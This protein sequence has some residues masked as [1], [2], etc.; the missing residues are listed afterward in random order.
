MKH[1]SGKLRDF[2][3]K[4]SLEK[5]KRKY[6]KPNTIKKYTKYFIIDSFLIL[7]GVKMI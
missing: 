3:T 4:N 7:F 5:K 6:V 2:K 1:L